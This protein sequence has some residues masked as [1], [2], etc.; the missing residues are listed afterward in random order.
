MPRIRTYQKDSDYPHQYRYFDVIDDFEESA[1]VGRSPR[2]VRAMAKQ[3]LNDGLVIQPITVADWKN[4][5]TLK[6]GVCRVMSCRYIVEVLSEEK[7]LSKETVASFRKIQAISYLIPPD[8]HASWSVLLNTA[9]SNNFIM[10]YTTI[11]DLMKQNK[12]NEINEGWGFNSARF[13]KLM[14][15]DKLTHR[16][17]VFKAFKNG[18]I[19]ESTVFALA[20]LD[21]QRQRYVMD[22]YKEKKKIVAKDLR[23]AKQAQAGALLATAP[24]VEMTE[25]DKEIKQYFVVIDTGNGG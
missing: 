24:F 16:K 1:L 11:K 21:K 15:L 12:W 17:T 22:I 18:E 5:L 10:E 19:A 13:D 8:D 6:D 7:N 25:K 4:E 20:K 23:A 14:S 9:R 2:E 3:L